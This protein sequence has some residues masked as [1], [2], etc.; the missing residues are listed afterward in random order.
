MPAINAPLESS[1]TSDPADRAVVMANPFSAPDGSPFDNDQDGNFSTGALNTGIGLSPTTI[2]TTVTDAGV[3]D[4]YTPGITLPNNNAASTATLIAIGGG[5]SDATDD[6]IADTT[7]Y[8]EQPL[9]AFGNGIERD[10]GSAG[11]PYVG[12]AVKLVTVPAL[13]APIADGAAIE[14][15]FLNVTGVT[16]TAGQSAFGSATA[17]SPPITPDVLYPD[18]DG[19]DTT[20]TITVP[21]EPVD[22]Y[23]SSVS[24]VTWAISGGNNAELFQ[25]NASTGAL[26]F[27]DPSVA[28]TYYVY[29]TCTAPYDG[30]SNRF[31]VFVT[32]DP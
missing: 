9:L 5:H 10:A 22:T 29:V 7:P 21:D 18:I 27:I 25:I 30:G 2:Y 20:P 1:T 8:D 28:G 12:H 4:N 16:M 6:G 24:D 14:A 26:S 17:D 13:S 15:N 23:T 3:K 31:L 32:V 11:T 19:G